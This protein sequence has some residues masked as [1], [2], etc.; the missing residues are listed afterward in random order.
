MNKRG[1]GIGLLTLKRV[2]I[3]LGEM[4][5]IYERIETTG[6]LPREGIPSIRKRLRE[7]G[8]PYQTYYKILRILLQ[9][10]IVR[11]VDVEEIRTLLGANWSRNKSAIMYRGMNNMHLHVLTDTGK[12]F[13]RIFDKVLHMLGIR[14]N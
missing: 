8:I 10:G 1:R 13:K 3:L 12:E 11:K 2:L 14:V 4:T 6:S 5:E 9:R 7:H